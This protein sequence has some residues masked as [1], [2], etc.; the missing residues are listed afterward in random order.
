[1]ALPIRLNQ[2]LSGLVLGTLLKRMLGYLPSISS[3]VDIDALVDSTI[4]EFP[5]FSFLA[6]CDLG[7]LVDRIT[8]S[9]VSANLTSDSLVEFYQAVIQEDDY[10]DNELNQLAY[11]L[12]EL[13]ITT[14]GLLKNNVATQVDQLA[15]Q[16]DQETEEKLLD[17]PLTLPEIF[18][19][20]WGRLADESYRIKVMQSCRMY[21]NIF[22]ENR[23]I[24]GYYSSS[25]LAAAN[26]QSANSIDESLKTEA[27]PV[28][29]DALDD[30]VTD[31]NKQLYSS[32]LLNSWGIR[33]LVAIAQSAMDNGE[34]FNQLSLYLNEFETVLDTLSAKTTDGSLSET[35]AVWFAHQLDQYKTVCYLINGAILT[36][37]IVLLPETLIITN[38]ANQIVVN[39]FALP[40]FEQAG[41]TLEQ[42]QVFGFYATSNELV[43]PNWGWRT[44]RVRDM[45]ATAQDDLINTRNKTMQNLELDNTVLLRTVTGNALQSWFNYQNTTNNKGLNQQIFN[46]SVDTVLTRVAQPDRAI[47]DLLTD[48]VVNVYN[49]PFLSELKNN[50]RDNL[51][52]VNADQDGQTTSTAVVVAVVTTVAS[53][54]IKQYGDED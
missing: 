11:K 46:R 53:Y 15:V 36:Q 47:G 27:L 41:G 44:S 5:A 17:D 48:F 7:M 52:K 4:G 9:D 30:T 3:D 50:L 40:A 37:L 42:I 45:V 1:M 21:A 20:N 8:R 2:A 43:T 32:C 16:I 13:T 34:E 12:A 28:I 51:A 26:T 23:P 6:N 25:A 22:E 31:K 33:N 29:A 10:A 24:R 39:G 19:Q 35:L 18:I 54:L 49:A 14:Y 38:D